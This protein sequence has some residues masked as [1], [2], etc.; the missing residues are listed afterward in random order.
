MDF[1]VSTTAV[2]FLSTFQLNLLTHN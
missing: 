1:K 2:M